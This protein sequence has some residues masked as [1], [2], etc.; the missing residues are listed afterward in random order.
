V[1]RAA[2]LEDLVL[3]DALVVESINDLKQRQGFGPMVV[4]R[5]PRFQLFSLK[6][7]ADGLWVAEDADQFL[8]FAFS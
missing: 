7:D 2:R 6:D 3:A 4:P 5:P 1:C 8:G